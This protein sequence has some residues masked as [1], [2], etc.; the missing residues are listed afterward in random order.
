MKIGFFGIGRETYQKQF[1]G[2]EEKEERKSLLKQ[3]ALGGASLQYQGRFF[4][5]Q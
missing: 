3:L 1:L 4:S 2:L 5:S